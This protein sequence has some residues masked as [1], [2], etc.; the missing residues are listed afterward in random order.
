[1][2]SASAGTTPTRRIP[3]LQAF[4]TQLWCR[5][6][7]LN[8]HSPSTAE[9]PALTE[10]ELEILKWIKHG[11]SNTEIAEI[12]S[13]SIKT[14]EYHVGNVLKKLGASN[15]TTAVVIAIQRRLLAL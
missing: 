2:P 12:M 11:K 1:M 7:D 6:A 13:L 3:V 10:R 14:V 5:Y 8:G 9:T 4:C 15:R